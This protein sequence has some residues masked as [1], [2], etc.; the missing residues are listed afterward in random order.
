LGRYIINVI[1]VA[2]REMKNQV[3]GGKPNLGGDGIGGGGVDTGSF[4]GIYVVK[5]KAG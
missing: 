3:G 5:I 2:G 4:L 1:G